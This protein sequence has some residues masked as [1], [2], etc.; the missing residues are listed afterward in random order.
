MHGDH[1]YGV[2]KAPRTQLFSEL[3]SA[4][5]DHRN[6]KHGNVGLAPHD[7]PFGVGG[8]TGFADYLNLTCALQQGPDALAK[9][10]MIVNYY[11]PNHE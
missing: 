11:R 7:Q 2:G 9:K 6:I 1:H 10:H 5:T 3:Q 4:L 8:I